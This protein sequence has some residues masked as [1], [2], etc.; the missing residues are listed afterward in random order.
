MFGMTY[1]SNTE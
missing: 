1:C